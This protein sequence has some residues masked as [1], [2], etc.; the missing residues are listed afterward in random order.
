MLSDL[1]CIQLGA[2]M[3]ARL[4]PEDQLVNVKY[5]ATYFH[6]EEVGVLEYLNHPALR[7]DLR[8]LCVPLVREPLRPSQETSYIVTP[9]LR[10][11]DEPRFDTVGELVGFLTQVFRVSSSS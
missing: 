8:N 5:I 10:R 7:N 6:P 2:E 9:L 1:V 11:F 4:F 3:D